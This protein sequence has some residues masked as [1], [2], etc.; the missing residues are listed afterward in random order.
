MKYYAT[1]HFKERLKERNIT[2]KDINDCINHHDIDYAAK[3]NEHCHWYIRSVKGRTLKVL[4]DNKR[5]TFV[6]AAWFDEKENNSDEN[7]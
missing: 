2:Q 6:T 1:N 7:S 4:V 3:D 5:K